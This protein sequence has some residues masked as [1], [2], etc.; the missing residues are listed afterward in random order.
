MANTHTILTYGYSNLA[1]LLEA[2]TLCQRTRLVPDA[3]RDTIGV[4]LLTQHEPRDY[5]PLTG[6]AL[7][8]AVNVDSARGKII[9]NYVTLNRSTLTDGPQVDDVVI[10]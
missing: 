8:H 7:E 4:E 9:T 5:T 6:N 10:T 2:L 1:E 3:D